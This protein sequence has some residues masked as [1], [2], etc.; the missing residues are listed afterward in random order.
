[1]EYQTLEKQLEFCVSILEKN[2]ELM[3]VLH[4]IEQLSLPNYYIAAGAVFQT[5][6]NYQDHKDLNY[7]IKDIDVIYYDSSNLS[8]EHDLDYYQKIQ[9][10]V[11]EKGYSYQ[12]DVSNEA[13]MHLWKE[14]K[15]GEKV[16]PYKNSEDA[17]CRWIATVHAIG[18]TLENKK[19]QVYAPYGLSDLLSRTIR[20]IR[21]EGNSKMLYEKKAKGWQNRFSHVTI[22]PW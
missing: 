10:Y 7:G 4:F 13:R 21:H 3:D 12:V 22:V 14:K 8:V 20:P 2:Q 15:D 5:I 19:L 11:K 16:L 1:M 17:I 9:D 18:I 6:W